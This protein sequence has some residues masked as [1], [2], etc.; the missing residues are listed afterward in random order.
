MEEPEPP[1]PRLGIGEVKQL[2]TCRDAYYGLPEVEND[3]E[4]DE[5][6]GEDGEGSSSEGEDD[7]TTI[8]ASPIHY[9]MEFPTP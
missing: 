7:E 4:G 2:Q 3:K 6:E 5:L 9:T 1:R 8:S